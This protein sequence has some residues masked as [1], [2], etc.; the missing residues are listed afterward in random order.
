MKKSV[1]LLALLIAASSLFAQKGKVTT[2]LSFKESGDLKK[3]FE[4]IEIAIDTT[5]EKSAKSIVWPNTWK[6]RGEILQDIYR[7]GITD[8]VQEPLF[9]ALFSYKKAIE[10]D[11]KS[12][13]S[14]SL[15]IDLTILQTDLSQQAIAAYQKDD[16]VNSLKCFE[17]FMEISNLSVMNETGSEVLDTAIIYNSGLA[18]FKAGNWDKALGYFKKSSTIDYNGAACY[19]FSYEALRAKGDTLDA[20]NLIKEGFEKYPED[21]T[22]IVQLINYYINKS[23]ADDAINYLDLAIAKNPENVSYYTAKGGTLEKLGREEDA[24]KVYKEAIKLDDT[25]FTPYYNLGVIY[26][27]RGVNVLN[28]ASQL[29]ASATKEYDEKTNIGKENLKEAL[30]FIEKAYSIDS[31]EVAIMESLRLIYYRLQMTD[32]YDDINKKIQSINK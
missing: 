28:A 17:G 3:A 5:N 9:K 2:A 8:L 16:F 13:F 18:A 23:K 15:Q 11:T 27:N 25:Q 19:N 30:P 29:P 10:L 24:I 26:Y 7:K 31:T 20:I 1:T 14:K 32:K 4:A 22:L 12:K 6:V 21:E